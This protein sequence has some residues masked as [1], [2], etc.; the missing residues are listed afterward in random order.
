M[1]APS[2]QPPV[3][4]PDLMSQGLA[5]SLVIL[6]SSLFLAVVFYLSQH[7][8]VEH[9]VLPPCSFHVTTGLHCP[10]C[11]GLRSVHHLTNGRLMTALQN[12]PAFV[13]SL[14][15]WGAL[16]WTWVAEWRRTGVVPTLFAQRHSGWLLMV[17]ATLFLTIGVLRNLPWEPFTA[18]SPPPVVVE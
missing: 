5:V 9:A 4:T 10:G 8:P 7:D 17:I 16:L 11:G 1:S 18:L 6:C 14:P 3:I 2:R 12:H 13:L 15:M